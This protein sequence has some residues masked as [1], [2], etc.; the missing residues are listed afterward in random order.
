MSTEPLRKVLELE[1]NKGY[2]D[3]AVIGGL[4]RFLGR[5]A[6]Q[7]VASITNPELLSYFHKLNLT[8]PNYA[9]LSKQQRK[10]WVSGA[11]DFLA[12]AGHVE[13]GRGG[14]KSTITVGKT[15]SSV[16]RL[17]VVT[18]ESI[19]APVT[20]IKG[21]SSNLATKFNKLE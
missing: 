18:Y 8:S 7:A 4:D 2:I 10:Q 13:S 12:Q 20:V 6:S 14:A 3:S 16:K 17:K 11:L 21:V 5:W 9:S 1:R 19:E 15:S